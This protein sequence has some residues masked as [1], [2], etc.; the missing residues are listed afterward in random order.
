MKVHARTLSKTGERIVSGKSDGLLELGDEVTFEARHLGIR[1]RLTSKVTR[2]ERPNLFVDQM[3][4]GAFKS[5]LHQHLFC[6]TADGTLMADVLEFEAPLGP[7][8]WLAERVF[9]AS[10]IRSVIEMRALGL[11]R[12]AEETP[13]E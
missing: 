5:L 9:L 11:K 7:V 4:R 10:Y 8:G 3:T 13:I 6:E 2:L 12:L 1:Q